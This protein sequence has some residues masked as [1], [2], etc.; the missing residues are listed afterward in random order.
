MSEFDELSKELVS[1]MKA[2][3]RAQGWMDPI[4][5]QEM[6]EEHSEELTTAGIEMGK[7][8]TKADLLREVVTETHL[9]LLDAHQKGSSLSA[10][11]CA[12][13]AKNIEEK[14]KA[15]DAE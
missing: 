14:L 15:V 1:I 11:G 5:I 4:Q 9:I 7:L 12:E 10:H 6:K 8:I 13:I 2:G 3:L